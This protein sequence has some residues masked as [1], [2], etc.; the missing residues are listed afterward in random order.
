MKWF[1]LYLTVFCYLQAQQVLY[2]QEKLGAPVY[3]K[4][5]FQEQNGRQKLTEEFY[6]LNEE[7]RH[8]L[9]RYKQKIFFY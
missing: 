6:F 9:L 7:Q 5:M 4:C 3:K 2:F 8:A 1:L